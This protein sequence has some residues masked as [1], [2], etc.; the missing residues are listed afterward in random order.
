MMAMHI[1]QQN[2]DMLKFAKSHNAEFNVIDNLDLCHRLGITPP[3]E[4][5]RQTYSNNDIKV[6]VL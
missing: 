3:S 6:A 5:Y 1:D 2:A 4:E